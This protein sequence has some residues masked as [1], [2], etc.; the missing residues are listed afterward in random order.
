M[1][2]CPC[3]EDLTA[4]FSECGLLQRGLIK[5]I[6]FQTTA[7]LKT[8][9]CFVNSVPNQTSVKGVPRSGLLDA[10]GGFIIFLFTSSII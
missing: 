10:N 1:E 3:P 5:Q 9:F 8:D 4:C 6:V 2:A 7:Q